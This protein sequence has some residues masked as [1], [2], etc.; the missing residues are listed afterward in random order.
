MTYPRLLGP[1]SCSALGALLVLGCASDDFTTRVEASGGE[2]Q[3]GEMSEN[4]SSASGGAKE[5]PGQSGSGG[6]DMNGSGGESTTTGGAVSS[7][8]TPST[9]GEPA[10]TGGALMA[11][12]GT[13]IGPVLDEATFTIGNINQDLPK[14]PPCDDPPIG[15]CMNFTGIIDGKEVSG[16]CDPAS[17]ALVDGVIS[18]STSEFSFS[19]TPALFTGA[20]PQIISYTA[21]AKQY[22]LAFSY[23]PIGFESHPMGTYDLSETHVQKARIL[24]VAYE[25]KLEDG[26]RI[27]YLSFDFGI[28]WQKRPTAPAYPDVRL[29]GNFSA[30]ME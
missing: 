4:N 17:Y 11:P 3:G 16:T 7:G 22:P 26:T 23:E 29:L 13:H 8:G 2:V 6:A 10:G 9:G 21:E 18:C 20:P 28:E 12:V 19:V 5:A 1:S 15:I 24:G 14:P 25:I 27:P 30:R